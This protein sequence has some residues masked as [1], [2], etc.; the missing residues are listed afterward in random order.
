ML[1]ARVKRRNFHGKQIKVRLY[2]LDVIYTKS[3][4]YFLLGQSN[5]VDDTDFMFNE[6]MTTTPPQG[7]TASVNEYLQTPEYDNINKSP[8]Q[9]NSEI[10]TEGNM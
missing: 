8:E 3:L 1:R 6:M 7:E 2:T 10:S 5:A 9:D 4:K